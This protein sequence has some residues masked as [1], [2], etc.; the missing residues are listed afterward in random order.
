MNLLVVDD[1]L[2][3]R[4]GL[5]HI[6][7]RLDQAVNI[8]ECG[9]VNEALALKAEHPVFDLVL[10]DMQLP[11]MQGLAGL[12]AIQ[13][14][15]PTSPIAM[16]S[17][18]ADERLIAEGLRCGA[19]GFVSKSGSADDMLE[20]LKKVINGEQHRANNLDPIAASSQTTISQSAQHYH[21]TPRQIQVLVQLCEGHSNKE[22]GRQLT[23]SENTVRCH[24]ASV[25]RAL[26]A[27]SRTEAAVLAKRKGLL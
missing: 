19:Q 13:D 12:L 27:K 22:I 21:L 15:F 2:L 8:V 20:G 23:M 25:F 11:G 17:G 10:L 1:H 9:T 6:L 4:E 5:R 24:V 3:F 18:V 14:A 26:G 7:V 16:I